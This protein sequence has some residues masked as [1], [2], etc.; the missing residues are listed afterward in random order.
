MHSFQ[1]SAIIPV[2][3]QE[4]YV[5]RCIRSL[6][7]QTLGSK[8]Y[9]LVVINDGSTDNTKKA[10]MPFMGDIRYFENERQLGLP[11][12]LNLGIKKA[13]GQFVVRVDADDYVHWDYLKIL[14]MHLQMNHEMDAIACDYILVNDRQ[15]E[16]GH[17]NC[18]KDGIGCGV[19]F[20]LA[21]LIDI[22]LYD[23]TFLLREDED[24][25]LR[26]LKKY[27]IH[28]VQLPLYRYRKHENN[29]TRDSQNMKKYEEKLRKK[30]NGG[31]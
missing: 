1:V 26:F 5:G 27:K 3:N 6:L 19:M 18:L 30:H 9:E 28:R 31:L 20:R 22:G 21:Q 14:S 2:Y 13:K 17:K 29:I 4:K 10:L 7:K 12:S 11:S 24:L 15:D 23:E 25:R 16:L 8:D